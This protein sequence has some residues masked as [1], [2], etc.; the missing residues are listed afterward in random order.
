MALSLNDYELEKKLINEAISFGV[1]LAEKCDVYT[2]ENGMRNYQVDT[3][4]QIAEANRRSNHIARFQAQLK[5]SN[6]ICSSL[7]NCIMGDDNAISYLTQ[8]LN[9]TSGSYPL[10]IPMYMDKNVE[11]TRDVPKSTES[12]EGYYVAESARF[13]DDITNY[14]KDAVKYSLFD[15]DQKPIKRD[16]FKLIPGDKQ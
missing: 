11:F 15:W 5:V 14:F 3:P 1:F 9:S 2:G 7:S 12:R 8:F 16:S 4:V 10:I 13:A 6:K